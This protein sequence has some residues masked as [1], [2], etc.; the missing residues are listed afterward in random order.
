MENP[1]DNPTGHSPRRTGISLKLNSGMAA[2][3]VQMSSHHKQLDSLLGYHNP[4]ERFKRKPSEAMARIK[5]REIK[6]P[7]PLGETEKSEIYRAIIVSDAAVDVIAPPPAQLL[8]A[9]PHDE[10]AA[11][12]TQLVVAPP[13]T[14]LVVAPPTTQ[15]V[16]AAP[17]PSHIIFAA[18]Q[19]L[20]SER[21]EM[22]EAALDFC[23][24][25][26]K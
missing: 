1:I 26:L 5:G 24:T 18:P 25:V 7:K 13:P 4:N 2:N 10:L 22:F 14:Q 20:R 16:V 12:P 9:A 21:L 8:V 15:Q 19:L 6:R 23:K 11:P 3:E 17:P